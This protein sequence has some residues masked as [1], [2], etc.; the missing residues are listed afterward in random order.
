VTLPRRSRRNVTL[1]A[2]TIPGDWTLP[3]VVRANDEYMPSAS[4]RSQPWRSGSAS[5]GGVQR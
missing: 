5:S 4:A 3:S 1:I 2:Y